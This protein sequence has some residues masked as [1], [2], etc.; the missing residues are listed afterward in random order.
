MQIWPGKD[1]RLRKT[2]FPC[3]FEFSSEGYTI[4]L[5]LPAFKNTDFIGFNIVVN[6]AEGEKRAERKCAW[7][8][9]DSYKDRLSFGSL[10]LKKQ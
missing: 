8:S 4:R 3:R 7:S 6:D 2:D 5:T 10:P 9:F 1:S